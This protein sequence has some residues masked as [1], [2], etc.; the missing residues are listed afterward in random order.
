MTARDAV[1]EGDLLWSPSSAAIEGAN[2]TRFTAWLERDRGVRFEDHAALWRWSVDDLEGFWSAIWEYFGVR[3]HAPHTSVLTGREMPGAGW[4]PGAR[5]NYAEH[6]LADADDRL[7]VQV[8]RED[9]GELDLTRAELVELVARAA[10]GLRRLGVGMGDRVAAYLPNGLEALVAMLATASLGAVW[11][12]CSPDFGA[13]AVIDRFRQIEPKVLIAAAGYRYGGVDHDRR[14]VVQAVAA[15]L[16]TLERVIA[17]PAPN[18]DRTT[19]GTASWD[20]VLAEAEPLTFAPVPFPHPLWILYSSGTT[21]LPKPIVHGHGGMLL[22]HLKS[23]SLHLDLKDGDRF[24]WF[25][26]TGWMMWNFLV[27]GLLLGT[28]VILFDGSPRHPSLAALWRLAESTG[29]TYF[30]TSAPYVHA[31][32][33]RHLRPGEIADLSALRAVGSTGAPLSPEGFA[34]LYREVKRDLWVGSI[35]G[36]TDVCTAFVTSSP[37]LPV[38]AGELQT[39]GYGAKVEAF[40]GDG[41]SVVDEVGELVLTEPM[42]CMPVS[43]WNDPGGERYRSSYFDT[44][45]GVWRHGDWI[46]IT[47]RDTC[48]ISGRSDA[49]LNRGGVRIG[50]AELYRIV[51]GLPGIVES[52]VVD[53][54][55]IGRDGELLLFVSLEPGATLDDDLRRRIALDLRTALSPRHVPDRVIEVPA[56]PKTLNGKRLEIPVKRLLLGDAPGEVASAGA[57]EDPAA[58]ETFVRLADELRR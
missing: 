17:V 26:T 29:M 7:A 45:P 13:N 18:G 46:R 6:A 41:R 40:D 12:S 50:T 28:S 23:L 8:R 22:E 34:W 55:T 58:F 42:P 32:L 1:A 36:G 39:R 51:D 48:V 31:C 20:D 35:S 19:P 5:I 2:V 10:T 16:P 15:G 30:G 4:F 38:H 25:T 57:L 47:S 21:G 37:V 54:G 9:G 14:D 56:I 49:T 3:S 11:S 27:S 43:F 24:F 44:Y 33:K 52:L 53:T